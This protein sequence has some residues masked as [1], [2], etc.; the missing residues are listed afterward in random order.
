MFWSNSPEEEMEL[1][2]TNFQMIVTM[3]CLVTESLFLKPRHKGDKTMFKLAVAFSNFWIALHQTKFSMYEVSSQI[4]MFIS[5][6]IYLLKRRRISYSADLKTNDFLKIRFCL[7]FIVGSAIKSNCTSNLNDEVD[8]LISF[9]ILEAREI[10]K[11]LRMYPK[12]CNQFLEW[13]LSDPLEVNQISLTLSV[14]FMQY[15]HQKIC[16]KVFWGHLL[17][18]ISH[19]S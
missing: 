18:L 17:F 14:C 5:L 2:R 19:F 10:R 8:R 9:I 15:D 3:T 4:S 11:Q 1:L 7:S 6:V 16:N 13:F 12:M